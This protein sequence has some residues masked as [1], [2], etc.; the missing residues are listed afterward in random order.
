MIN[1]VSIIPIFTLLFA[2]SPVFITNNKIMAQGSGSQTQQKAQVT[3]SPTANQIQNQ[4]QVET[5][6][7][8]GDS[9][10]NA[11]TQEQERLGG[12]QEAQGEGTQNETSP[13]SGAATQSVSKAAQKVEEL[14]TTKTIQGGIGQQVKV[15]AQEQKS[16]QVQIQTAL[17]KVEGRVGILKAI[18]GPDFNALK[19]M[20]KQMEQNQLRIQQLEELQSQLVNQEEIDQVQETIRAM[21]DQN[22]ALQDRIA[23]EEKSFSAFGW[24][25]KLFAN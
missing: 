15:I 10:I 18:I 3:L 19:N 6:N 2:A 8:G 20:Q 24:L 22:V 13:R 5:Q 1:I 7:E 4:I 11:N 25:F 17:G 9:Q 12:S 21:V 16:A 14:L 23:L